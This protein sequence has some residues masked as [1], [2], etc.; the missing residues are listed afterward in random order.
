MSRKGR[1]LCNSIGAISLRDGIRL[2][3][4]WLKPGNWDVYGNYDSS[5]FCSTRGLGLQ[6]Q[7][8]VLFAE[9]VEKL[10][11]IP[12]KK[13]PSSSLSCLAFVWV[14]LKL[15]SLC[16]GGILLTDCYFCGQKASPIWQNGG[17]FLVNNVEIL[18]DIWKKVL[19]ARLH[20]A[21][22]LVSIVCS[23]KH[24]HHITSIFLQ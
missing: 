14:E 20:S 16:R 11:K 19:S 7:S 5:L 10:S 6:T 18:D 12:N 1:L 21:C 2:L 22:F 3:Q 4:L 24:C 23:N 9:D 15:D 17:R 8:A 13:N